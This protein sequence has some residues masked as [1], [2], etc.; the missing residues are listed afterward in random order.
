MPD[1][2][3]TIN[4]Q[5]FKTPANME[6]RSI[7]KL[8]GAILKL[9]TLCVI[10]LLCWC[11]RNVLIYIIL[12]AVLAFVGRPLYLKL[13]SLSVKKIHMPDALAAALTIVLILGF[14]IGLVG[15]LLP[16]VSGVVSDI[17][18]ANIENMAQGIAV[19]L[20]NF[21]QTLIENFPTLDQDFKI[22]TFLY[23]HLMN[24]FDIG[25]LSSILGSAASIIVSLAVGIFAMVFIA[26]FFIR[27]P[28]IFTSIIIALVPDKYEEKVNESIGEIGVLISRYLIGLITEVLGVSL[29]NF[30]GL[31][32][33]AKMGF[34]Y[35]IGI[36][37]MTG[38]FNILPYVG[39]CWAERS[40]LSFHL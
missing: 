16:V 36:A 17:S 37:M 24:M 31:F 33:I 30:L 3:N 15:M 13:R 40:D 19:P 20:A 9:F 38:L 39:L 11:F 25:S 7:D 14:A 5:N 8:A 2:G 26:F 21:N 10:L 32:F 12:A 34:R 18:R 4:P 35:S 1:N 29:I 28:H 22:E 27:K 6:E 23:E